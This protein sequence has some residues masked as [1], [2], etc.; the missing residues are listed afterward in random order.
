M[1]GQSRQRP[2]SQR[3]ADGTAQTF[4]VPNWAF[5][6]QFLTPVSSWYGTALAASSITLHGGPTPA[7]DP[8]LVVAE[9]NFVVAV[10]SDVGRHQAV[11]RRFFHAAGAS[12]ATIDAGDLFA[13]DLACAAPRRVQ[14]IIVV[15]RTWKRP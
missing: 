7:D 15:T 11:D 6:V 4:A 8:A 2:S 3:I 10:A 13:G 9:D 12:H 14:S 1:L 5:A